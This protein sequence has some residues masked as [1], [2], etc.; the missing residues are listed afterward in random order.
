[1]SQHDFCFGVLEESLR[2]QVNHIVAEEWGG[3]W[4]VTNGRR[5]DTAGLPGYACRTGQQL[6][7]FLLLRKDALEWEIA[8][9]WS[10]MENHGIATELLRMAEESA[11]QAGCRRIWLET[12]NDNI[13]AFR[14]YQRRGYDLCAFRRNG[15]DAVR[16]YKPEIPPLGEEG[17][18][19]RHCLEFEKCLEDGKSL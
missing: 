9:L 18:P 4:L 10:G 14:F 2:P 1:M 3:P 19:L 7:G 17:I 5:F 13:R 16:G 12:T 6:R 15:M 11:R 8:V